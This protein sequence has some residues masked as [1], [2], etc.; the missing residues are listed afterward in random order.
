M[1]DSFQGV[2]VREMR[3]G[4]EPPEDEKRGARGAG[5]GKRRPPTTWTQ[6]ARKRGAPG[7]LEDGAAVDPPDYAALCKSEQTRAIAA[8]Q[9]AT[10]A[11]QSATTAEQRAT[12]A[13]QRATETTQSLQSWRTFAGT[14][15][16]RANAAEARAAAAKK[17]GE[18]AERKLA[19]LP[20]T[21]RVNGPAFQ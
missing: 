2:A 7:C 14:E 15:T 10:A 21:R 19:S 4:E 8:E 17:R 3:A 13:E 11:E 16:Q 9:R 18:V 20:G 12:A 1:R 6:S 5:Q